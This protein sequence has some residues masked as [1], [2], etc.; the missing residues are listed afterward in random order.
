MLRTLDWKLYLTANISFKERTIMKIEIQ[1]Q[2]RK[3][4]TLTSGEI[5][6]ILL[7]YLQCE[8]IM[9][10]DDEVTIENVPDVVSIQLLG[11][12]QVL[13]QSTSKL[14]SLAT[15]TETVE[16]E[17]DTPSVE[18]KQNEP[19]YSSNILSKP[20][21][22]IDPNSIFADPIEDKPK[23]VVTRDIFSDPD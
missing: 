19:N 10:H 1:T 21:S 16:A 8:G 15:C 20:V 22:N 7:D 13:F 5:E 17:N 23:S 2:I 4:L 18:A 9:E 6:A 12:I 11:K 3:I 14:E